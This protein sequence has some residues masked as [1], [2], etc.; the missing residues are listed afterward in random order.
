V[1][2]LIKDKNTNKQK[3]HFSEVTQCKLGTVMKSGH[4]GTSV[5]YF[6]SWLP[7]SSPN[8][9]TDKLIETEWRFYVQLD[10]QSVISETQFPAN[11]NT[12]EASNTRIT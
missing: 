2:I 1:I 5:A 10:I 9:E 3:K 7:L 4:M 12:R 8:K 11:L 6:T